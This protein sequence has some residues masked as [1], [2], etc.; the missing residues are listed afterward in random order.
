[1]PRRRTF[2]DTFEAC[3]LVAFRRKQQKAGR[4][5][6][7]PVLGVWCD[8]VHG[9]AIGRAQKCT[10]PRRKRSKSDERELDERAN[11]HGSRETLAGLLLAQGK[12]RPNPLVPKLYTS[13]GAKSLL[14]YT[15]DLKGSIEN[16]W[17][18]IVQARAEV[19]LRETRASRR[20]GTPAPRWVLHWQ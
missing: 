18:S 1:M 20:G 9:E 7:S 12:K 6:I 17:W 8:P 16:W 19:L 14:E 4:R 11:V 15:G 5:K 13:Q 2:L 3:A 10:K